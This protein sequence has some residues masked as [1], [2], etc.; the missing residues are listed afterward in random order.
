MYTIIFLFSVTFLFL[1]VYFNLFLL[2][3]FLAFFFSFLNILIFLLL[4]FSI[5]PILIHFIS[6]IFLN[7]LVCIIYAPTI[8]IFVNGPLD[9]IVGKWLLL[10]FYSWFTSTCCFYYYS[11]SPFNIVPGVEHNTLYKLGR[12]S[13]AELHSQPS[14]GTVPC[15]THNTALLGPH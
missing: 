12:C 3:H 4:H 9:I 13:A 8:L 11:L 14:L 2:F 6:I 10:S 1:I 7:F 15:Y 5:F